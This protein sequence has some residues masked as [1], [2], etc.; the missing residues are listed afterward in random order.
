M[1]LKKKFVI[2]AAS[3]ALVAGM[4][5]A[6][7]M[8]A[9]GDDIVLP[10]GQTF[11]R[12]SGDN[13]FET[14]KEIA[15]HAKAGGAAYTKVYLVAADALI[16]AASS[17][18]VNDGYVLLMPKDEAGQLK[19]GM[20]IE[21]FDN[22][23]NTLVAVGGTG[24]VSD[25]AM[26]AVKSTNTKI[27][28]V[29]RLGGKD[30]Y[31]TNLAVAKEFYKTPAANKVGYIVSG[32][33]IV[34]VLAA[35]TVTNGPLV[36]VPQSGMVPEESVKYFKNYYKT[37][38]N[39]VVIGGEGAVPA[40]QVKQMFDAGNEQVNPW[41]YVTTAADLRKAV[42]KSA[43][44]YLGQSAWQQLDGSAST[45][46]DDGKYFGIKKPAVTAPSNP[47]PSA[48][49]DAALKDG[50]A[51]D[52]GTDA[53]IGWAPSYANMEANVDKMLTGTNSIAAKEKYLKDA[54]D[55]AARLDPTKAADQTKLKATAGGAGSANGSLADIKAAYEG[56]YGH[57]FTAPEWNA[58]NSNF[59]SW[60]MLEK[61]S[62][63]RVAGTLT[64]DA[65]SFVKDDA[66][67]TDKVGTIGGKDYAYS[68]I[69]KVEVTDLTS[70]TEK[71]AGKFDYAALKVALNKALSEQQAKTQEAK[72]ALLDAVEA[73]KAGPDWK[74]LETGAT[75][76]TPRLAGQNRYETAALLSYYLTEGSNTGIAA[77]IDSG[78]APKLDESYIASGDDAHLVD[79]MVG[80]QLTKGPILLVPT[81]GTT[82]NEFTAAE[83]GRLA[84]INKDNA[85]W[86][87][88]A[89]GGK[90][91]VSQETLKAVSEAFA[92]GLK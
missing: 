34:D 43:A 9:D 64:S 82:L 36:M 4:G 13:R 47:S 66:A 11:S 68:E 78:T 42:Q 33:S 70:I 46:C 84:K 31:A 15:K 74:V 27:T 18:M 21:K 65:T 91:A 58:G 17:G 19:L 59:E 52:K 63:G 69:A 48:V 57:E 88:F 49:T 72:K 86:K 12:L 92:A 5:V 14:A 76:G 61:D 10:G 56:L 83:M 75:G 28:T 40:S 87:T 23:I 30:R 16:D 39:A 22:T 26:A 25:Q 71:N 53:F 55:A 90:G 37:A 3:L 62:L 45:A 44:L 81:T 1:N 20:W 89:L 51:A 85:N 80:G 54:L 24:V 67:S 50:I 73:C 79:A 29:K 38:Q 77:Q 41:K 6:P 60:G 32:Q 2:G 8:A 35:G 7:A